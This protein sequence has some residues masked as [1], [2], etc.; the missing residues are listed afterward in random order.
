MVLY[1]SAPGRLFQLSFLLPATV[2]VASTCLF[3]EGAAA[4]Q[5]RGIVA[6]GY[7]TALYPPA[8]FDV[9]GKY[10]L[11]APTTGYRLAGEKVAHRDSPLREAVQVGAYVLVE[12]KLD[13]KIKAA[14]AK[15]V[16]FRGD[17]DSKSF[18]LGVIDKV[19]SSGP[20]PIFR[21][22]GYQTRINAETKVGFQDQLKTLA[23]VGLGTWIRFEGK[24]SKDGV[25]VA[26]KALF[27]TAKAERIKDIPS[28]EVVDAGFKAP[29]LDQHKDGRV[30]LGPMAAPHAI[31]ADRD[32]QERVTRVGMSVLP[33]YQKAMADGNPFKLEF[34]FY[35]VDDDK[36]RPDGCTLHGNLILISKQAVERLKNDSQLAAV[37]ADGVALDLYRQKSS[38]RRE[39]Y[40]QTGPFIEDALLLPVD[41][42]VPLDIIG[43]L[44]LKAEI[45][46][47]EQ[48]GRVA[49]ALMGDAGY[50]PW[51]APEAWRLL[52][53]KQL[54]ND[55][56]SL[57][58]PD[59]SGYQLGILNLQYRNAGMSVSAAPGTTAGK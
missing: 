4:Q 12:G 10:V 45:A 28:I 34:Q 15:T 17:W 59:R 42:F 7:I 19:V 3:I 51:Q 11:T 26:L 40:F 1:G 2:F 38:L 52:A 20:E 22:D 32:V 23:D 50:D 21:A 36:L 33:F 37:L 16:V 46:K 58:Y 41:V 9:N 39:N 55:L 48:R 6:E 13:R 35:A 30:M 5:E 31:P 43:G 27:F 49:L 44:V 24:R 53:P 25:V 54:P 8:G 56:N 47:V 18:G 29:D 14:H 57:R